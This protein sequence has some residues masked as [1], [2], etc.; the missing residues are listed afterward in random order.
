LKNILFLYLDAF[1]NTGGIEKFNKAFM[2]A[3]DELSNSGHIDYFALSAYDNEFDGRYVDSKKFKGSNGHKLL[4][5]IKAFFTG[6]K[7]D[8]IILGHL[9][10]SVIGLLISLFN[11]N[12]KIYLI[13][14]GIEAWGPQ[15][16]FKSLMIK[17]C[18]KILAVSEF[19]KSKILEHNKVE[20][21]KINIFPNT[22]DP[23]FKIPD[24]DEKPVYLLERYKIKPG[25]KIILTITR[26][27]HYE[28]YKGYD[29]IIESLHE[30][31]KSYPDLVYILCG[32][33]ETTEEKRLRKKVADMGLERNFL[34]PGYVAET[35]ITDHYQ[36]ADVFVMP[37]KKEGFGIV[38][39]EALACGVPVI[40]GC[41]DGSADALLNGTLGKLVD[42]DSQVEIK[43]SVFEILKK[44]PVVEK[45]MVL[46]NFGYEH[47]KR[48]L[49][50]VIAEI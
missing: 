27:N 47:F 45:E 46:I 29:K 31:L 22:L 40:A 20:P 16:L 9:N 35:E 7:A 41:K 23:F 37:S 8:L 49:S 33:P 34:L 10:L 32:K 50:K 38:F 6:R 12:K 5:G 11:P 4:F 30:I 15:S 26:I 44:K 24:N 21:D 17:K 25:T 19:T 1:L 43:N 2:K 28:G 39:I 3:L 13:A 42:P 48:R 36:L 18:N 14:H